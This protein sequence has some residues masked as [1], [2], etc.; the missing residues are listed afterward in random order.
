MNGTGWHRCAYILFEHKQPLKV[1][2][3]KERTFQQRSFKT[4]DFFLRNQDNLTPVGLCFYQTE[5]DLSARSIFHNY[6]SKKY[7]FL[8]RIL[9]KY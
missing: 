8:V 6:F 7:L 1:E 4:S 2:F 9:C 5:W 3:N